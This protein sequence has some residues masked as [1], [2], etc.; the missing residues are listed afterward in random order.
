MPDSSVLVSL[1]LDGEDI[2]IG[3][4]WAHHR[5][6]RESAAFEYDKT[7]LHH[8]ERFAL[9]PALMLT[10]GTFHTKAGMSVFGAIG[11]SA[12]NQWGRELM[13]RAAMAKA[14]S[15]NATPKTLFE[16]DYLLGVSDEARQ[17]ALRFSYESSPL[18]FLSSK[19]QAAIP[20][21]IYLPKL[22]SATEHCLEN[23]ENAEELNLLWVP[24]SSLGGARPKVSIRDRDTSLAI[25]KLPRHDDVFN[26]VL[27]EATALTLA[28]QAGIHVPVWRVETVLENPVL[29]LQR[30]D[31]NHNHRIP[32]ISAMGM[33]G[34]QVNEPHSYLEIA[35]VLAQYGAAPEQDMAEL[36][37]RMVFTIM[38][39]NT[40]DHLRNH[41]FIYE[42][43][44]G[45]RLS[46]VFDINP[47][48]T[49]VKP[50]V[51]TTAIDFLHTAASLETALAVAKDFRLSLAQ[52]RAIIKEVSIA[53]R[54][55]RDVA[56]SLGVSN[57]ECDL[58][59]SAFELATIQ[60]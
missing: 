24:G 49:E 5:N 37:R 60:P 17:G 20:P 42:R 26:T 9:E 55:W 40:D 28:K 13:R 57:K 2:R 38:I 32:Y 41:G 56:L 36:W 51:L 31:R 34:A 29:I 30:F 21:L 27:W 59:A 46:P 52:A 15:E 47:T 54:T 25:A 12:P 11:D 33:L 44:R 6:G 45:W 3:K 43:Y 4:L 7:W 35:Y 22:L 14:E 23:N 53:V 19:N 39:S 48:P 18:L 50:H 58:M 10:E 16:I 1:S 8:P